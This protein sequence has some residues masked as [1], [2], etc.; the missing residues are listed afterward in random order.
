MASET[1]NVTVS[2]IT[3]EE[4]AYRTTQ[5]ILTTAEAADELNADN[6]G[7]VGVFISDQWRGMSTAA[8]AALRKM[9]RRGT[10]K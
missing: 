9:R 5:Y 4:S 2:V 8:T 10:I 6:G 7:D 3:A 1:V